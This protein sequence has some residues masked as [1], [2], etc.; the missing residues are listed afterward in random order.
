MGRKSIASLVTI[1]GIVFAVM[2]MVR[3]KNRPTGWKGM[4]LGLSNMLQMMRR[5]SKRMMFRGQHMLNNSS[6]M[7]QGF[8][9]K[10][11]I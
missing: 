1:G 3:M 6:H 11:R 5:S 4:M 2:Q 8:R 7:L 10:A 9:K